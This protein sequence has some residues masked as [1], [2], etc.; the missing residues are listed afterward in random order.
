MTPLALTL[1]ACQVA[2]VATGESKAD[3]LASIFDPALPFEASL[4]SARV[5][6]GGGAEAPTWFVDEP[7]ARLIQ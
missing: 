3:A 6:Q 7:A 5:R 2:F 1:S 4:P